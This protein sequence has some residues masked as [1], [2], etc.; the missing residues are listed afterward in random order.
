MIEFVTIATTGNALDFGD[1]SDTNGTNGSGNSSSSTRG[2]FA[3]F[4]P[5]PAQIEY[6]AF[7]TRGDSVDFMILII[8][9]IIMVHVLTVM[10]VSIMEY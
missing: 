6:I 8:M 5:A 4:Y 10:E 2:I 1:C 7:A 9:V 3:G